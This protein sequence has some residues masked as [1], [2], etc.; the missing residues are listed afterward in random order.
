MQEKLM[1]IIEFVKQFINANK[2]LYMKVI[3]GIVILI[4]VLV[5]AYCSKGNEYGNSAGNSSNAGIAV[6]DGKWIYYV[7][8]D[9]NEPVGIYK[10]KTNGKNIQKVVDG[11]MY[12]LNIIDNKI[13]C[14]EYDEDNDQNNLIKIKTNGKGKEI[15]A[16]N[17]DEAPVTAV[18]KWV[19]YFKNDNLYRVKLDGTDREKISSKDISYYQI[20]GE[21]IYYIY[22]NNNSQYIARMELD[23]EDSERIA[24]LDISEEYKS[25]EALYVK[26]GKIY[27]IMSDM[28]DEYD[29]EY[30][31]YK[32]NKKGEKVEKICNLDKNIQ[33]INM[34]EDIICY[35][36]TESYDDYK[37]KS[38]KYN[39]TDK[40]TIKKEEMAGS[41][42]IAGDWIV[43]LGVN[44]DYD[45]I[46][47]MVSFDGEKSKEL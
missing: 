12:C 10:V 29:T 16:R 4:A 8:V 15:L 44:E 43:Y 20:D 28:N 17:I 35:T 40:A 45:D 27:Y 25:Y 32:M 1:K 2:S 47:K 3:A 46:M 21:W 5:I 30:Y 36:V 33:E 7:E 41:I 37:I 42:N 18:G 23:G 38:I 19:Y 24:K 9:E 22:E 14:L 13:Y 34:Q 11:Y 39:G 6:Q 26:G 31:L